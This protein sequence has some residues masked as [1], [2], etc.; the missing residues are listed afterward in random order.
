MKKRLQH[1]ITR[2]AL[3][4]LQSSWGEKGQQKINSNAPNFFPT[5]LNNDLG[6][7]QVLSEQCSGGLK[8][9]KLVSQVIFVLK[10]SIRINCDNISLY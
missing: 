8:Q 4:I 9:G 7:A 5:G 3:V 1:Y 6:W 2:I 10:T